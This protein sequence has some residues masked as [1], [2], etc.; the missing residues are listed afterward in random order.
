MSG[1]SGP[2]RASGRARDGAVPGPGPRPAAPALRRRRS[3]RGSTTRPLRIWDGAKLAEQDRRA[4]RH[5]PHLRGRLRARARRSTGRCG[6][7][8]RPAATR[9]T[10]TSPAPP[11]KGIPVLRAPGRN[12]DGVAE[13]TLALL[14]AVNRHVLAG[15]PRRA[16]PARSS[17][18]ARSP[19]SA[20]GRGSSPGRTA[21]LVGL[22]AVGRAVT[23][24]ARGPRH[25]G[26]QLR[27]VRR[28]RHP[29]LA[30]RHARRVRRRVDARRADARDARDDG[31]RR[32]SPPCPRAR[33]TSTR[34]GPGCTTPTRSSPRSSR[35]TSAGAGLDHF[36]GEQL[37][38]G[39]P[40][41][42]M[43]QVVLTPH[44][45]GATYDTEVNHSLMI[46]EDV[47]RVLRGETPAPLRQPG[48]AA[49]TDTSRSI[50]RDRGERP[51]AR[52]GARRRPRRGQDDVRPRASSRAPPA[53]CR[54][55]STTAR[56]C[57][58]RRRSPTRR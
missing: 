31:R 44:I 17:A 6:S 1:S 21:G 19:T 23:L 48:G 53:T 7:S 50:G 24:A 30:R 55:G 39:H 5:R 32:S 33:S 41:L 22:G 2:S 40:L 46:A 14:F 29:R 45:G 35:A 26:A 42:A 3:I 34:R 37:P 47:A 13:M 38:E 36:E 25:A 12:A 8:A 20:S 54:A 52:R 28:G 51:P 16:R 49:M 56:S 9:P 43:D 27:P 10:S 4:R 57:S 15:R 18:T 11:T 58:P